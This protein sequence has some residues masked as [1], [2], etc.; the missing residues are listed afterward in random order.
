MDCQDLEIYL[1]GLV[2]G[3]LESSKELLVQNHLK[4]CQD[5]RREYNL[6]KT[7]K[8]LIKQN[9]PSE[10]APAYLRNKVVRRVETEKVKDARQ[11]QWLRSWFLSPQMLA[12][13]L[14]VL[15]IVASLI[16]YS[17]YFRS[18]A[19]QLISQLV[20]AHGDYENKRMSLKMASSNPQ[21]LAAW[22]KN[23]VD[24]S[25]EVPR[26][27]QINF[28]LLGGEVFSLAEGSGVHIL[29]HSS[30]GHKISLFILKDQEIQLSFKT[31]QERGYE[32]YIANYKDYAV[33]C[34]KK[35]G[36][37]YSLVCVGTEHIR[38]LIHCALLIRKE[39]ASSGT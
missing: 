1:S 28:S 22:F 26:L 9:I 13:A 38:H 24:F 8:D 12:P 15:I 18:P 5:C 3:E 21:Q 7:T 4:S 11:W 35:D 29:Y 37:V 16:S 14:V 6:L 39:T 34:W 25:V 19:G 20:T 27:D 23:K 36:L 2:D 32:F 31:I 33:L 10:K 17:I 30:Q